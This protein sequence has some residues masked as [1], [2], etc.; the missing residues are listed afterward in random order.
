MARAKRTSGEEADDPHRQPSRRPGKAPVV[1]E[2]KK[3][4]KRRSAD[5]ELTEEQA[6]L[7]IE[8][9]D[10]G[11]RGRPVQIREPEAAGTRRSTRRTT[12]TTPSEA[13]EAPAGPRGAGGRVLSPPEVARHSLGSLLTTDARKVKRLRMVP[14]EQWFPAHRDPDVPDRRFWTRLQFDFYSA[15][16]ERHFSLFQHSWLDFMTDQLSEA[17][18]VEDFRGLFD[19]LPGLASLLEDS[20]R[21]DPEVVRI[22]YATLYIDH[23]RQFLQFMFQGEHHRIYRTDLAEALG[24]QAYE[25]RVHE[26]AHPKAVPPRRPLMSG[27]N[28]T[29]EQI[30]VYFREPESTIPGFQRHPLLL[31]SAAKVVH[32]AIRRTLLPCSG[33]AEALTA[34]Q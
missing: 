14:V 5:E 21:Y 23:D 7:I 16:V 9:H 10:A 2:P 34:P 6:E 26:R 8:A 31:T 1:E 13:P 29:D 32:R 33:Y 11:R 25:E 19:F 30:R 15:Y 4:R 20:H 24:V 27:V 18:G 28:P 3:K 17:A 22:F 12:R